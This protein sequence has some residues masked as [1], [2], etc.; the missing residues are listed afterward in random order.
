MLLYCVDYFLNNK[1]LLIFKEFTSQMHLMSRIKEHFYDMIITGKYKGVE[2]NYKEQLRDVKK[3]KYGKRAKQQSQ[4]ESLNNNLKQ[5]LVFFESVGVQDRISMDIESDSREISMSSELYEEAIEDI[6][7]SNN[8]LNDTIHLA[9]IIDTHNTEEKSEDTNGYSATLIMKSIDA[10]QQILAPTQEQTE[11]ALLLCESLIYC[12][13]CFDRF[14]YELFVVRKPVDLD[15]EEINWMWMYFPQLIDDICNLDYDSA[16]KK[17]E[18]ILKGLYHILSIYKK[19]KIANQSLKTEF[20]FRASVLEMRKCIIIFKSFFIEY[21]WK[22]NYGKKLKSSFGEL[23]LEDQYNEYKIILTNLE[24]ISKTHLG[25]VIPAFYIFWEMHQIKVKSSS[26]WIEPACS[27]VRYFK[28]GN[29]GRP[30]EHKSVSENIIIKSHCT[31]S[32]RDKVLLGTG[33]GNKLCDKGSGVLKL[34]NKHNVKRRKPKNEKSTAIE[35]ENKG[36]ETKFTSELLLNE[37]DIRN[38]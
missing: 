19:Y 2:L 23:Y 26:T 28:K 6:V 34:T 1:N 8:I 17:S 14:K 27:G 25:S 13:D 24:N 37:N 22:D 20:L 3:R 7:E 32:K 38:S 16:K 10:P 18:L 30:K 15:E 31:F 11:R 5:C 4:I 12:L 29:V 9:Q 21:L 33:V 35:K 36:I